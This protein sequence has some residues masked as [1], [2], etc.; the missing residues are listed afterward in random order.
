MQIG[1]RLDNIGMLRFAEDSKVIGMRKSLKWFLI[2]RVLVPTAKVLCLSSLLLVHHV[3]EF[4]V[5]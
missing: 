3:F 1:L 5:L 4:S 2:V